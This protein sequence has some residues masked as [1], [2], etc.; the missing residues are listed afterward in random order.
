MYEL[1]ERMHHQAPYLVPII[2]YTT[3]SALYQRLQRITVTG[4]ET[5]RR[6]YALCL[7]WRCVVLLRASDFSTG[8]AAIAA[9]AATAATVMNVI[10]LLCSV[11][12]HMT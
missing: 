3:D 11:S 5:V 4:Q 7:R 1:H 8:P 6:L 9:I 10:Q 2:L 12:V